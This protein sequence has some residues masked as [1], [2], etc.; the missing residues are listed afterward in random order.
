MDDL[1][2]QLN[3][4]STI[5]YRQISASDAPPLFMYAHDYPDFLFPIPELVL[6]IPQPESFMRRLMRSGAPYNSAVELTRIHFQYSSELADR[7]LQSYKDSCLEIMSCARPEE[8]QSEYLR[9]GRLIRRVYDERLMSW[10]TEIRKAARSLHSSATVEQ[11]CPS[12]RRAFFNNV[13]NK[14]YRYII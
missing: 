14:K 8:R 4:I 12:R 6:D 13:R 1:L 2:L 5:M 11:K 7:Y 3:E 9:L 10:S